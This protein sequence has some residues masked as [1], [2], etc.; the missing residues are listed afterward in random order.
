MD[1]VCGFRLCNCYAL[2]QPF[3]VHRMSPP[4]PNTFPSYRA[5]G[6]ETWFVSVK[7]LVDHRDLLDVV[8]SR[9]NTQVPFI[10]IDQ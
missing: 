7:R 8:D 3:F 9:S 10:V 2:L 1:Q 6:R 5:A 4:R